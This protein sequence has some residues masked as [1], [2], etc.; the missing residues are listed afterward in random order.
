MPCL[1]PGACG[2]TRGGHKVEAARAGNRQ[3]REPLVGG[4][5]EIARAFVVDQQSLVGRV[6]WS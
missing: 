3:P 4:V 5:G 6:R 1:H 2:T